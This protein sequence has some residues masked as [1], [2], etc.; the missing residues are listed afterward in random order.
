MLLLE[1][2]LGA[3]I[4]G[5][6]GNVGKFFDLQPD[7]ASNRATAA[8]ASGREALKIGRIPLVPAGKYM[9]QHFVTINMKIG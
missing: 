8:M 3:G 5:G 9:F 4:L 6:V 2:G 7:R 1:G